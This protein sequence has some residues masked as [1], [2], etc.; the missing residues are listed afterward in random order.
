MAYQTFEDLEAWVRAGCV[1]L[2]GSGRSRGRMYFF[3]VFPRMRFAIR[4]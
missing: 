2:P 3:V 4:G 1:C